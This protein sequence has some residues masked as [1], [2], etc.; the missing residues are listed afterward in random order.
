MSYRITAVILLVVVASGGMWIALSC[1][2]DS[3]S[4]TEDTATGDFCTIMCREG[5][6]NFV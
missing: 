2:G 4:E 5:V 6:L 1:A 3:K